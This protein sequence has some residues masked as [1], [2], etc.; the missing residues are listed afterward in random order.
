MKEN[1]NLN[2]ATSESQASRIL[3]YLL[4]GNTITPL[5]ALSKFNCFRLGARIKDI[6]KRIG[7]PPERRRVK[8]TNREGKDV[9]VAQYWIGEARIEAVEPEHRF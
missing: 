6:E 5:E 1:N 4:E 8:V 7:Y 9:Y 2:P 3:N